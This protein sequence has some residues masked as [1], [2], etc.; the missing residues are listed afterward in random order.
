M[1]IDFRFMIIV[2]F[3]LIIQN[4]FAQENLQ[5]LQ[6]ENIPEIL[7]ADQFATTIDETDPILLTYNFSPEIFGIT[8]G[9]SLILSYK[10]SQ[11][12][13]AFDFVQAYTSSSIQMDP[14][15]HI[16]ISKRPSTSQYWLYVLSRSQGIFPVTP[17]K[18]SFATVNSTGTLTVQP[19]FI[20]VSSSTPG[21]QNVVQMVAGPAANTG[22]IYTLTNQNSVNDGGIGIV[23]RNTLGIPTYQGHTTTIFGTALQNPK[24]LAVSPD[25]FRVASIDDNSID[26]FNSALGSLSDNVSI[27]A[28]VCLA[29]M[30][31]VVLTN[32]P[33]EIL[34][35]GTGGIKRIRNVGGVW[36]CPEGF[37]PS[38]WSN[39]DVKLSNG[40]SSDLF[41]AS[42]YRS[43]PTLNRI[44][45]VKYTG[46]SFVVISSVNGP[47]FGTLPIHKPT[48]AALI[49]GR[50]STY[51]AVGNY[52]YPN[53]P[54]GFNIFRYV[55][56]LFRD[57]FE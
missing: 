46:S 54:Y 23:S 14:K 28:P 51:I 15:S 29:N 53:A 13:Q 16:A 21:L 5:L 7:Y 44:S 38:E 6:S 37:F 9:S 48:H 17:G 19:G 2:L 57:G 25:G 50:N 52:N 30:N 45:L 1:K 49:T 4:S 40:P 31:Y 10:Y 56:T 20:E 22:Y 55:D 3:S 42:L 24:H 8:P 34:A 43:S 47:S 33:N 27:T 36:S 35:S 11:T 12:L 18:L 39:A 26:L 41:F 32:N